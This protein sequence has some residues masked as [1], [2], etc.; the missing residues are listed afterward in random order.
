NMRL[1]SNRAWLNFTGLDEEQ[2]L[3]EGWMQ[4]VHPED[5]EICR[6]AHKSAVDTRHHLRM[7]YRLRRHDG[8]FRWV[9]SIGV[10]RF[11]S[12]GV[13]LGLIGSAVDISDRKLAEEAVMSFGGR[14]ISAQE[15]ERQRIA[16]ELHDDVGQRLALLTIG[17]DEMRNDSKG[18]LQLKASTL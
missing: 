1:Y 11:G 10:P 7:E 13:F 2:A 5:I 17:L 4:S 16:R 8:V 14:L 12:E 18:Q 3:G 15:N 9:L 6:S